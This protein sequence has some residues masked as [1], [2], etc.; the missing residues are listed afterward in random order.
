MRM[1]RRR[2]SPLDRGDVRLERR[3]R[4]VLGPRV[5][6]ALVPAE[7]FLNVGRGLEDGRD[8]RARALIRRPAPH[9]CRWWRNARP[10]G[11][12]MV[13]DGLSVIM[14]FSIAHGARRTSG[15]EPDGS[16]PEVSGVAADA[17]RAA[18][19]RT[20]AA[21]AAGPAISTWP[22]RLFLIS[23]GLKLIVAIWRAFGELP[24]P[25]RV[26]SGA[27][28]VGLV[29][30]VGV[31][32]WRLF[33]LMKRRLLWRVR[34][35]LILSYIFIGV[36]PSLLIIVFFLFCSAVLFMGVA[37]YLFKERV[38]QGRRRRE[39]RGAG[40]GA[41]RSAATRRPRSRPSSGSI[42]FGPG[43]TP[44]SR[45]STSRPMGPRI[46]LDRGSTLASRQ[47]RRHG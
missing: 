39:G 34:R 24:S 47:P 5:L 46:P 6:V 23:A 12:L 22:G 30:A 14:R 32:V 13:V 45:S 20:A 38:R 25:I 15:H 27:A 1:R 37:A 36:V 41:R 42:G 3:A 35:K 2:P 29:V 10:R 17:R 8:D 4:R 28:T 21:V 19:Q 43:S 31:F 11:S 33:I 40:G 7:L 18:T 26:L 44:R 9:G 16:T